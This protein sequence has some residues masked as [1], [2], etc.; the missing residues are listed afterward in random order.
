MRLAFA[1]CEEQPPTRQENEART[2]T[3]LG[4]P[5]VVVT[6]EKTANSMSSLSSRLVDNV[7]LYQVCSVEHALTFA[8]CDTWRVVHPSN[9]VCTRDLM[10]RSASQNSDRS[11]RFGG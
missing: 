6:F 1:S 2:A 8:R 9:L 4:S 11:E 10:R 7:S 3:G 5:L